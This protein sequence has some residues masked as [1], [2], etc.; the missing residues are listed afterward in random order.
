MGTSNRNEILRE[1]SRTTSK[2]KRVVVD[3]IMKMKDFEEMSIMSAGDHTRAFVKIQDGC[4][5]FCTYCIIPLQ[6][7]R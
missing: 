5:R 2:D 4:S 6:E 7:G 3:D 1:V